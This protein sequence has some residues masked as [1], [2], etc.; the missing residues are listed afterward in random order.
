MASVDFVG[1]RVVG[2]ATIA[3]DNAAGSTMGRVRLNGVAR[4]NEA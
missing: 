4:A 3:V 2:S 1:T